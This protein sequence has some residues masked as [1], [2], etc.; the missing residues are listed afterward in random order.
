[1]VHPSDTESTVIQTNSDTRTQDRRYC[2]GCSIDMNL[3]GMDKCGATVY[4]QSSITSSND[5][6]KNPR[7]PHAEE[8]ESLVM[9]EKTMLKVTTP[10]SL[11]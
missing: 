7:E 11:V 1:M 10:F 9:V 4:H 8:S 6:N 2:R 3:T 5:S